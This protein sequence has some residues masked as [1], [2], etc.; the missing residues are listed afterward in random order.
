MSGKVVGLYVSP[1]FVFDKVEVCDEDC[2]EKRVIEITA[3]QKIYKNAKRLVFHFASY[4]TLRMAD[5]KELKLDEEKNIEALKKVFGKVGKVKVELLGQPSMFVKE[6]KL[7]VELPKDSTVFLKVAEIVK[8]IESIWD[9]NDFAKSEYGLVK[10]KTPKG[11]LIFDF[12]LASAGF[13]GLPEG[14]TIIASEHGAGAIVKE[15]RIRLKG[16]NLLKTLEDYEDLTDML[17]LSAP[18]NC[19]FC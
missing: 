8:T 14:G 5:G 11:E 17:R 1:V 15:I 18:E 9:G 7:T 2:E 16:W 4:T 6:Y 10:V 13:H 3:G 19:R 12:S